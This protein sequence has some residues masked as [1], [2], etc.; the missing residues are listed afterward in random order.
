MLW[1]IRKNQVFD[2]VIGDNS[3]SMIERN[4]LSLA[5]GQK[6]LVGKKKDKYFNEIISVKDINNL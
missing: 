3:L 1:N 5:N 6:V 4:Y 2:Y